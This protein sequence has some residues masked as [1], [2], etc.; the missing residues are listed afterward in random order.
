VR[1][2]LLVVALTGS[3]L[4]AR[5]TTSL[6]QAG[7]DARVEALLRQGIADRRAGRL[8]R[9]ADVFGQAYAL[10]RS[11]RVAVQLGLTLAQL[12]RW[13]EAEQHLLEA[14]AQPDDAF[15]VRRREAIDRALGVIR[16]QLGS[17]ELRGGEPGARVLVD[18]GDR[19]T[20][21]MP[22]IRAVLGE[23]RVEVLASDGPVRRTIR[24]EEGQRAHVVELPVPVV[25]SRGQ[26][27][28]PA[29][30][31][32]DRSRRTFVGGAA[33]LGLA[34]A[35]L[36]L[37]VASSVA[38]ERLGSDPMLLEV[39]S[40]TPSTDDSVCD[41]EPLALRVQEIC[42]R[43]PKLR[44]LQYAGYVVAGLGAATTLLLWILARREDPAE[45]TA[46]TDLRWS[47]GVALDRRAGSFGVSASF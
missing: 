3:F 11:P 10:E 43:Y 33:T 35:A 14:L 45:Q 4:L 39:R 34:G 41:N 36:V 27:E 19:G 37:G 16:A 7:D 29:E 1:E 9:A 21:P 20:L 47:F 38:I 26:D 28:P 46:G 22:P 32:S 24:L 40:R 42:D 6:A 15:V 23:H 30:G 12:E 5:P 17:I 8:H 13:V 18:G 2:A 25:A 44:A 31:R